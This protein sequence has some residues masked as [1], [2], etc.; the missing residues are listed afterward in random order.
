MTD[1]ISNVSMPSNIPHIPENEEFYKTKEA[2]QD[3]EAYFITQSFEQMYNTVP[4]NET[5]G[6]GNGEKIFRSM[7]LAEYGKMTAQNGGI[8]IT[9]TILAQMIASQKISAPVVEE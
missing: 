4:V 2:V 1:F 5:F 6:G 9:D 3:F 8:G 7:L